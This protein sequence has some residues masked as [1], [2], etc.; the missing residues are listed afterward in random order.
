MAY[1]KKEIEDNRRKFRIEVEKLISSIRNLSNDEQYFD[2][3]YKADQLKFY[4]ERMTY[5][6]K[7]IPVQED[8]DKQLFV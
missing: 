8:Y 4:S 6:H 2:I 1:T 5:W 3:I 7:Q